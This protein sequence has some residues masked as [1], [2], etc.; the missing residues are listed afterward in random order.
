LAGVEIN[1][2]RCRNADTYP[3]RGIPPCDSACFAK[4]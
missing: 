3:L 4:A 2:D 1:I